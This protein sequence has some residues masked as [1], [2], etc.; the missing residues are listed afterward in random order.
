LRYANK[1]VGH[2]YSM[3]GIMVS[4]Q[5]AALVLA[6]SAP[7]ETVL[8]DFHASWC[9]PCRA[10]ESTVTGLEQAGYPVR[11]VD[12]DQER[13]MAAQYHVQN[14]P[15]F[16]LVVDG[17]EAGRLTGGVSQSELAA[18]FARAG[19]GRGTAGGPNV[20][21]QSP[22][23]PQPRFSIPGRPERVAIRD[24]RLNPVPQPLPPRGFETGGRAEAVAPQELIESSVRLTIG[25]P[26]GFSYGSGTLIDARA[27]EAL[28]L[29]CGHIFRDSQGKGDISIDL[30]GPGAPQ[31]VPG[32]IVS[33]DLKTD[34]ALVSFKPGVPVRVA[35]LAPRGYA[36]A[37]GD[38]VTTVGCNNGGSPT[39]VPS[40]IT[41]IDKF[42]GPPNLQ[43]AG[44]P[45]QGR[46]GG[47]L[48]T[49]D[50]QVIG[51]CNAADPTDNEG[52]YAALAVIHQELDEVGLTAV[53][54]NRP[55]P[56]SPAGANPVMAMP[57]AVA[58]GAHMPG[59]AP[60]S[61]ASAAAAQALQGV[62]PA[63][64]AQLQKL[65][66][67]AEVICIVRPLS[68][69]RAKSEVIMLDRASQAFLQQLS[70]DR[71]AQQSRHLTSLNVQ[72]QAQQPL[73]HPR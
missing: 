44:L 67:T 11:R 30:L 21:A 48:F 36:P 9:G 54:M 65:G 71:D 45:V 41:A 37:K 66:E 16:V 4:V 39:A 25:D 34:V 63:A 27:G 8:L 50:G 15:C 59:P 43:V 17:Q 2:V 68:N 56:S 52:L 33:Y 20:R 73:P 5:I 55:Q 31:K 6:L 61:Q 12:V 28:V 72:R 18:M 10:M 14:I 60:E 51:V 3:E 62:D 29:T 69:P 26:Q 64:I 24:A 38:R 42:L 22:D 32:R 70:V 35:P 47:G 7:G 40:S 23:S 57:V 53:Y 1:D 46:S 49:A 19:V 13:H 58:A